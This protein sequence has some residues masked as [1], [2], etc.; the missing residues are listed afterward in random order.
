MLSGSFALPAGRTTFVPS[1]SCV[2]LLSDFGLH[3]ASVASVKGALLQYVPQL[4]LV[5]ISH[6]IEPFHLQQAAYILT[7]CYER[8]PKGTVHLLLF[9][10]FSEEEPS[11]VICEKN[12]HYF[13][14]PDNGI[15]TLA[16]NTNPEKVR[17]CFQLKA[18]HDFQDWVHKCGEII[19]EVQQSGIDAL[20]F[21]ATDLK[22]APVHWTIKVEDN[23]IESHVIHID[24]FE[25]VVTNITR[26]QFDQVG[27][28][29]P[30]RIRFMRN[31]EIRELSRHYSD[32]REGEKLCRFNS[33]GY[34]E[35]AINRGRA[36]SL[37]GL[38]LHREQHLMY[39]TIKLYFE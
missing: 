22:K 11:L 21:P 5:D 35:I 28:G 13:L 17:L 10:V 23:V 16:F 31:E 8:F 37:F 15:L 12:G 18:H 32:V 33:S 36:A 2:T 38:R 39:N 7:S 14:A 29:R 19:R 26:E 25:N 24:R 27:Q 6:L 34:L 30:F 9:D 4:P 20:T 3:D 1:M